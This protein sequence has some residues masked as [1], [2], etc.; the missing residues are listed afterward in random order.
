MLIHIDV[1]KD[2]TYL[3]GL[4]IFCGH[5]F[6]DIFTDAVICDVLSLEEVLG[7]QLSYFIFRLL[8][9]SVLFHVEL[10]DAII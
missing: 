4:L 2:C 8:G 10:D 9:E 5:N 3:V 6:A 1:S 7:D